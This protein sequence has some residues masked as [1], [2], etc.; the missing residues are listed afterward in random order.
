MSGY[1][2][3]TTCEEAHHESTTDCPHCGTLCGSVSDPRGVVTVLKEDAKPTV[4]IGS[5]EFPPKQS[6][7]AWSA[8]PVDR[9]ATIRMQLQEAACL[10]STEAVRMLRM[11][12]RSPPSPEGAM[13]ALAVVQRALLLSSMLP[14][15]RIATT[16]AEP[17]PECIS[18][19]VQAHDCIRALLQL[20]WRLEQYCNTYDKMD[21]PMT[22]MFQERHRLAV[23]TTDRG[24]RVLRGECMS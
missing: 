20:L 1:A 19:V 2:V 18:D 7:Y 15:T 12:D 3:C 5:S 21:G 9:D 8:S 17:V 24:V 10:A 4:C 6:T 14:E 16:H 13:D 11:D 23:V 22:D